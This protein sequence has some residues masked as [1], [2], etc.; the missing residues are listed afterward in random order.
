[1]A[2]QVQGSSLID[3]ILPI[4]LFIFLSLCVYGCV[5]SE[6]DGKILGPCDRLVSQHYKDCVF[7]NQPNCKEKYRIEENECYAKAHHEEE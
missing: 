5:K 4:I 7:G 1:M 2:R 3:I 6:P